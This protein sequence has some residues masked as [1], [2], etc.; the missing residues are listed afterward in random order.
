MIC[1]LMSVLVALGF[2]V[3]AFAED[4]PWA[5]K[6]FSGNTPNPPATIVHDF[7]TMPKGTVRTHRFEMQNIYAV[8]IQLREP[9]PS[10]GCV[11]VVEYTGKMGPRE[12]GHLL[13]RIDTSR[14]EGQK[15]V[16]LPVFFEGRDPTTNEPLFSEARLEI[17]AV[18]RADIMIEAPGSMTFGVVPVGQTSTQTLNVS[19]YGNARD[20]KIEEVGYKKDLLDVKVEEVSVRGARKA[21]QVKATLRKD[22]KPGPLDDTIVLKTND[23]ANAV[24][25]LAVSGTVQAPLTVLPESGKFG[26]VVV[27]EK[28]TQSFMV[29]ADKL[30]KV[31]A[32]EGQTSQ[33]KTFT[34]PMVPNKVQI[35]QV[36]I[37]P[38]AVGPV[39]T[40]LQIKTD[41]GETISLAVEASGVEPDPTELKK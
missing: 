16:R 13:I 23:R 2:A 37:T 14:V 21:Y 40:T 29:R 20:W 32:I 3:P 11:S 22:A 1:R 15:I 34:A 8:P 38:D 41:T 26:R 5:N 36:T 30:F 18:S 33:V 39:K 19:Y 12:T 17:R 25:S 7:G 24:L 35:I 31:S 10:C 4:A 28:R 9:K 6:F 27:G